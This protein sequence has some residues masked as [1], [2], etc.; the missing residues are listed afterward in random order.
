MQATHGYKFKK[1]SHAVVDVAVEAYLRS[2]IPCGSSECLACLFTTPR[3]AQNASHYVIPDAVAL[4]ELLDVF[5]LPAFSSFILLTSVLRKVP[6]FS[7]GVM[8]C[9]FVKGVSSTF[10][11]IVL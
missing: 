5:E 11:Q 7:T 10:C 2:D 6:V 3:L 4:Q 1:R 9:G 8:N